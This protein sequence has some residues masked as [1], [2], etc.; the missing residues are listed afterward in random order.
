[1]GFFDDLWNATVGSAV[2]GQSTFAAG[3]AEAADQ[4]RTWTRTAANAR[5]WNA[6]DQAIAESKIAAAADQASNAAGFFSILYRSWGAGPEGWSNLG[7]AF[8]SAS[9]ASAESAANVAAGALPSLVVATG[10]AIADEAGDA[11]SWWLRNWRWAAP[12]AAV[13]V[14][15]VVVVVAR[16]TR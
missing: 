9:G 15:V 12:A 5:G 8:A 7:V 6:A 4:A 16:V 14:V 1:M 11:G 10:T 3:V 2:A 13:S